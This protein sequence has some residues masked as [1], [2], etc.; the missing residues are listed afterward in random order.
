MAAEYRGGKN[1]AELSRLLDNPV[2]LTD[3]DR[4]NAAQ[5]LRNHGTIR[6]ISRITSCPPAFF[7]NRLFPEY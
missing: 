5:L 7:I 6:R 3:Y 1:R 2:Q 4:H